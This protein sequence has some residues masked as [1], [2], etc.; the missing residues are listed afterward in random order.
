MAAAARVLTRKLNAD[1]TINQGPILIIG[2]S[3]R[4]EVSNYIAQLTVHRI[5][6][7]VFRPVYKHGTCLTKVFEPTCFRF[8][9]NS[10]VT[11]C[12]YS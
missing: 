3:P 7:G 11:F 4:R 2:Y 10:D 8:F 12:V 1:I 5:E 9:I 6:W